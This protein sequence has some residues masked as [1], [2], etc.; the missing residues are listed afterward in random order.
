M[1]TVQTSI[2]LV[3]VLSL[4]FFFLGVGG[5]A[6]VCVKGAFDHS[7]AP[8]TVLIPWVTFFMGSTHSLALSWWSWLI[9]AKWGV[10]LSE[11][12]WTWWLRQ[13]D[14][15]WWGDE[16]SHMYSMGLRGLGLS[17]FYDLLHLL[18]LVVS[19]KSKWL[20]MDLNFEPMAQLLGI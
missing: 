4:C 5:G 7:W 6:V 2:K 12:T 9:L 3:L 17:N 20:R 13:I 11:S 1:C 18:D 10:Q 15:A 19:L 14:L 8:H 16:S